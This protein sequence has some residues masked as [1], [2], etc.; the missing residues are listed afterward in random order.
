MALRQVNLQGSS[1]ALV[2]DMPADI[3]PD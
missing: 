3:I 2:K 1:V